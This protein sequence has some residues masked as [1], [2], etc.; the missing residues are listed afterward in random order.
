MSVRPLPAPYRFRC[1][2]CGDSQCPHVAGRELQI[3]AE[4]LR[5]LLGFIELRL[6]PAS[7]QLSCGLVAPSRTGRHRV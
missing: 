7:E 1:D 4:L 6:R 3:K 5:V 2:E